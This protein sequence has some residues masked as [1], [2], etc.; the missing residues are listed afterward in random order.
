MIE[1]TLSFV[2]FVVYFIM[3]VDID[4]CSKTWPTL[5]D[6]LLMH[7]LLRNIEFSWKNVVANL[8]TEFCWKIQ[9]MHFFIRKIIPSESAPQELSNEWSCQ[10]VS[11]IL[12]FCAISVSVALVTEVTISTWRVKPNL[13]K[14]LYFDCPSLWM[15]RKIEIPCT[16]ASVPRQAKDPTRVACCRLHFFN[17]CRNYWA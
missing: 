1:K 16:W 5:F 10:Y 7:L 6:V 13:G 12:N 14:S 8:T 9:K 4:V 11:T 15:R 17:Q 3:P 2:F